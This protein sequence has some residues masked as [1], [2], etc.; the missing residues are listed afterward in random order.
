[1]YDFASSDYTAEQIITLLEAHT[2]QSFGNNIPAWYQWL[3]NEPA[4]V[5]TRYIRFKS[6]LY[7]HVDPIFEQYS[8]RFAQTTI[9]MDEIRWGGVVQDVPLRKPRI[10]ASAADYLQDSNIVFGIEIMAMPAPTRNEF[11]GMK[12]LSTRLAERKLLV[13]T[14]PVRHS[15]PTKP[16]TTA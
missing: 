15:N 9:R 8:G 16:F 2:G 1:M 7:L 14:A 13:F 11:T 5:T 3:W 6:L 10:S 4:D 12:C